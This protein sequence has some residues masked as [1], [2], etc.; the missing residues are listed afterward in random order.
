MSFADGLGHEAALGRASVI[1]GAE[2]AARFAAGEGR[3]AEGA[4][5]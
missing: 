1:T 3:G 2:G 4:G 5:V